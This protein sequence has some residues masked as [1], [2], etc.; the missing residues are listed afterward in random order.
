MTKVGGVV[1]AGLLG[2]FCLVP[3]SL[4]AQDV[5]EVGRAVPPVEDGQSPVTLTLDEAIRIALE[6]NLDMQSARLNPEIQAYSRI[7]A[8]ATYNPSFSSSFGYNHSS[9]LSTSQLDG[10][11]RITT[12][13]GTFNMSIN[14]NLPWYGGRL[15]AGIN[16][17]RTS[18]DN[19]FSTMNPSYRSSVSF[20]YNQPLLSGRRIDSQRNTL[21]TQ[22]ITSQITDIQLRRQV[23]SLTSQVRQSYWNLRSQIEQIEIQRR[24]LAQAKQLLENNRIRVQQGAM[25]ERDLAQAE[26]Q[27]ASAEQSLLNAEIQWRTQEFSFKRL[28][29]SGPDDPLLQETINPVD[30]PEYEELPDV[31][32]EAAVARALENRPELQQQRKQREIAEMNLELSKDNTRPNLNMSASYS[33]Q[34]V[35]G[36]RFDRPTLGGDPVLVEPGGYWDGLSSIANF[37]TPT[38]NLSFSYSRPIGTSSADASLE[39]ARIQFRQSQLDLQGQELQIETEVTSAGL[40]VSNTFHQLEAA[41]RSREASERAAEAELLRH[42]LGVTT[43]FNLASAQNSLTSARLSELRAMINYTNAIAEFERVQ[44]IGW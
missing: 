42:E 27:V 24:S 15:S 2:L 1:L 6:N 37:D 26:A 16:N 31:D 43:S 25:V 28:L 29:I 14:Q 32:I 7:A 34:G 11:T 33:L 18:T 36:D 4:H 10:G 39:R 3:A 12:Q 5:Y 20:S 21:R 44:G 17:S 22:H 13:R 30:L 41:R 9:N 19:I 35:G 8:Q 40:A 38:F 23:Q